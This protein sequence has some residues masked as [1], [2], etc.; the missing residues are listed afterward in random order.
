MA[1]EAVKA[2]TESAVP[3]ENRPPQ[4]FVFE[5]LKC[6]LTA[7]NSMQIQKVPI[8]NDPVPDFCLLHLAFCKLTCLVILP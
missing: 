1:M 8:A 7:Q 3:E 6:V 4:S 2:S 5:L